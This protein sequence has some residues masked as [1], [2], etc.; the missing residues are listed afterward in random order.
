MDYNHCIY[1]EVAFLEKVAGQ[2]IYQ[3]DLATFL[4][5]T[6]EVI[7]FIADL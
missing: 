2:W 5:Q 3:T 1:V 4:Q 6:S 7:F